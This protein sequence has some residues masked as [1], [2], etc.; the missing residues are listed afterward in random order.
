MSLFT[1]QDAKNRLDVPTLWRHFGLEGEPSKSCR[2]PFH[3]DSNASFSVTPDGQLWNCF[4]G[5][6]GGDAVTFIERAAGLSRTDAIRQ[7]KKLADGDAAPSPIP[8]RQ[9]V[10]VAA[11]RLLPPMSVGTAGQLQALASLRRVSVEGLTLAGARGLLR[12]GQ[13]HGHSAWFV[14]DGDGRNAQARRLDGQPFPT[15]SGP[16]KALTLPGSCAK[17]PVG[18]R[19]AGP[20]PA[21]ALVEGGPDML[22]AFHFAFCEDREADCAVVAMLGAGL[23]IH[24][25]ALPLFTGKRVRIFGH[26]DAAGDDAVERWNSQLIGTDATVDAFSFHGL[27]R[28]GGGEVKDLNDLTDVSPDDFEE[29]RETWGVLPGMEVQP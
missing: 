4:A 12:F 11:P 14:T 17:W 13:W 19:D 29:H 26:S 6:G 27:R 15:A 18:I 24:P 20:F 1:V 28:T 3:D 25:D 22:A 10:P 9:L 16:K 21:I 8:R 5:C 23:D 7:L 2:C